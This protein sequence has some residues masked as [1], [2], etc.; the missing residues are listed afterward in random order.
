M[1]KSFV[2]LLIVLC[3]ACAKDHSMPPANL[4]YLSV[5]RDGDF[6][7]YDIHY[8]SDVNILDLFGRGEGEGVV[9]AQLQ[10]ALGDDQDFSI[11]HFQR[12]SAYGSISREQFN[13]DALR[14]RYVTTAFLRKSKNNGSSDGDLSVAE[15][16]AML[17]KKINIPCKV[18]IT[19][20]GYKTYYSNAMYIPT[21]DLLREINKPKS[22]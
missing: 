11:G 6:G 21:S 9:A 10:C 2:P 20:Y 12:E 8:E 17:T 19:A 22:N 18:Y 13:K 15:L 5:A 1:R 7:L 3:S 4:I 14:Y 16:N